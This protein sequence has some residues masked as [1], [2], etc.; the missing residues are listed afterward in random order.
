MG[1]LDVRICQARNLPDTEALGLPDVYVK[2]K[3]ERTMWKT[4]T[5]KDNLNPVWDQVFKFT[6]ADPASSQL[7]LQLWNANTFSDEYMGSYKLSLSG[8]PMGVVK[9]EWCLLQQC[10][11]NAEIRVRLFAHDF[12]HPATADVPPEMLDIGGHHKPPPAAWVPPPSTM[13]VWT[14]PPAP[15]YTPPPPPPPAFVQPPAVLDEGDFR[16][17]ALASWGPN[18]IDL[19]VIGADN[20]LWSKATDNGGRTWSG[21]LNLGGQV[22]GGIGAVSWGPGRVDVFAT[23]TDKALYHK[24]YDGAW[25]DWENLGGELLGAPTVAS[26]A[27]N[28]LDV[29]CTGT[30][31]AL[32][33]KWWDGAQWNGFERLGGVIVGA[34]AACSRGP[35]RIDIFCRGTDNQLYWK[36]YDQSKGGWAEWQACGGVLTSSPAACCHRERGCEVSA[37]LD[38]A[39]FKVVVRDT[40]LGLHE[41][42]FALGRLRNWQGFAKCE[43]GSAPAIVV[44]APDSAHLFVSDGNGTTRQLRCDNGVWAPGFVTHAAPPLSSMAARGT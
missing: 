20:A 2:V 23:G 8:L 36:V 14:P 44:D 3:C 19:Y 5:V 33:H 35:G 37:S 30:D 12:G 18:R 6:V 29:F 39:Q 13:P 15:V 41:R 24:W 11:G 42:T 4:E 40:D 17:P 25:H 16:A 26:W 32:Y 34:P 1:R 38:F 31:N 9:D 43:V 7:E 21:W 28:R 22:A 10:K 27:P